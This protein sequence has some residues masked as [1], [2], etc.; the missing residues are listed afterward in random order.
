MTD[1]DIRLLQRL[2]ATS[3]E[4][5]IRIGRGAE[6]DEAIFHGRKVADAL[7]PIR[8]GEADDDAQE[9]HEIAV[10]NQVL[11]DAGFVEPSAPILIAQR[12][13]KP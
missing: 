10:R 1:P 5:L 9:A 8:D 11:A 13:S 3:V 12:S 6:A 4:T 2:I 7:G